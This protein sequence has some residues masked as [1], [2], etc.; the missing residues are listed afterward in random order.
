MIKHIKNSKVHKT[1]NIDNVI[2]IEDS[3]TSKAT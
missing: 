3:V 2:Y 1:I